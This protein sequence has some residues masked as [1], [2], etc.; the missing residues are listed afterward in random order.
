MPIVFEKGKIDEHLQC[1]HTDFPEKL[2]TLTT[3]MYAF[4]R[5]LVNRMKQKFPE[6]IAIHEDG[7][8]SQ[9]T[10]FKCNINARAQSLI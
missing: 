2:E 7:R 6:A 8:E 5:F 4:I 9:S 1:N 3:L 10:S